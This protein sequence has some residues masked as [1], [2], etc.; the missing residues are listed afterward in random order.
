MGGVE[1]IP[2]KKCKSFIDRSTLLLSSYT[3][4]FIQRGEAF[5][6]EKK[7]THSEKNYIFISSFISFSMTAFPI[8][9]ICLNTFNHLIF[10]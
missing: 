9:K 6:L 8:Q 2:R 1:T 4:S 3:A 7:N 10:N 5:N